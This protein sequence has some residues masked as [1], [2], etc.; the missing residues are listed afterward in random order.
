MLGVFHVTV[1]IGFPFLIPAVVI[2]KI[3]AALLVGLVPG[4]VQV[5]SGAPTQV[6]GVSF[7]PGLPW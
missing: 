2:E 4:N 7:V 5:T 6:G 3:P 1:P